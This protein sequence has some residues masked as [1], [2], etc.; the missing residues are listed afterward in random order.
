MAG[1]LTLTESGMLY[2]MQHSEKKRSRTH[3]S[4][5][6]QAQAMSVVTRTPKLSGVLQWL[7]RLSPPKVLVTFEEQSRSAKAAAAARTKPEKRPR[8]RVRRNASPP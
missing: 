7:E 6:N 5:R 3:D 4:N 8:R 2:Q 1:H